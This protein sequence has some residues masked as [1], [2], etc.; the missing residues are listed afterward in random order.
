MTGTG[1]LV[2]CGVFTGVVLAL[3]SSWLATVAVA[4]NQR[5]PPAEADP[6]ETLLLSDVQLDR[7]LERLAVGESARLLDLKSY[8]VVVG[9]A[10]ENPLFGS[11]ADLGTETTPLGIPRHAEMMAIVRP[12]TVSQAA[13]SDNL[14]I[15]TATAFS[16]FVPM[17]VKAVAGWLGGG[18]DDEVD[19][20]RF[21]GYTRTL[22]VD[23]GQDSVSS[24]PFYRKG[25]QRVAVSMR[26]AESYAD[27]VRVQIDGNELGVFDQSVSDLRVSD[28]LLTTDRDD[29]LHLLTISA[30]SG[31]APERP[32]DVDVVVVVY[33]T[34]R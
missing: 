16:V 19:A 30:A 15:A 11:D 9:R 14:G 4:Q 8:V 27:G 26:V 23:G 10:P 29:G 2:G 20:P 18:D 3:G 12:S 22:Q 31:A 25:E 1:R 6:P 21:A 13:G 34:E 28:D 24:V 33:A 7:M 32:V 5:Q 17:A